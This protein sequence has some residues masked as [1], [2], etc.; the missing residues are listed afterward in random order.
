[1]KPKSIRQFIRE[2]KQEIDRHIKEKVPNYPEPLNNGE[3]EA[4]IM[5]DEGLYSWAQVEGV[6]I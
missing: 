3:R 5:N 2:N 6:K 4:W 1:M